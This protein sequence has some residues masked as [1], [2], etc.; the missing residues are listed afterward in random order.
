VPP[1][2]RPLLPHL[3]A[4]DGLR[5]LAIASVFA[6]HADVKWMPG[7][8]LGV[9]VF[10]VISGFLITALLL[11][12]WR[13]ARVVDVW[14]FWRRRARRLLPAMLSLLVAVWIVVPLMATEQ[15]GRL[16]GDVWAA[17][18]YGSNWRLI[19]EHQSYFQAVGRPPL[20]QHLWSLAVEEQFYLVWPLLLWAGLA[21]CRRPA[22]LTKWILVGAIGSAV[23]MAA[24]YTPGTDP[25]RVY[26]GTDTRVGA[27]LLGAALA[28]VWAPW[29]STRQP[30]VLGRG[31]L[32][33][34][35]IGSL[36]GLVWSVA[37]LHQFD[38]MLYR[39]GFFGVA[40]ISAVLI[41]VVSHQGTPWI[42][43]VL[44]SRP[45]VWFGR[46]SYGLYL[47]HWPVIQLTREYYDVRLSGVALLGLRAAL[48]VALAALSYRFVEAPVRGGALGR[49]WVDLHGRATDPHRA[50]GR[51]VLRTLALGVALVAV[52]STAVVGRPS[53]TEPALFALRAG[54]PIAAPPAPA[55][56]STPAP[57]T[58]IVTVATVPGAV[59]PVAPLLAPAPPT[60]AVPATAVPAAAAPAIEAP[61]SRSTPQGRVT[62]RRLRAPRGQSHPR[63]PLT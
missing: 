46:R 22:R 37:R 58:T 20:L 30:T 13:R 38:D 42:G 3:R 11:A 31:V 18:A 52:V 56:S 5:A 61:V 36:A 27:I 28:C 45:L 25:S 15:S 14:G 9:D 6:Y 47:V 29:R 48:T 40:A 8:F 43:G 7:G 57:P 60:T 1:G 44:G 50:R 23:L 10:F 19:F 32:V 12:E 24:L 26:Y 17:L 39:G 33:V 53:S 34:F 63:E 16:R 21:V 55:P 59:E 51:V 62:G 41:A 35:G 4:L 2:E 54:T 49:L